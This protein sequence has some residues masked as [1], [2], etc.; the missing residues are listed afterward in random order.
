MFQSFDVTARPEQGPPRLKA[1]RERLAA[2]GLTGFIVP[3][4]DLHQGEYVAERDQRLQWL[5]GFTGSA[6]FCIV[7]PQIAGVFIDGR[8]RTQVKAQ[9]DLAHFT[10]VPWP[11]TKPGPWLVEQLPNGGVVGFDP[12]LH[13]RREIDEIETALDDKGVTLSPT[14]NFV[15]V[16]WTDQL[17]PSLGPVE[18][19]PETFAGE[20]AADKRGRLAEALAQNEQSAAV[21]TLPDS[22]SW[23]LNIRGSDVPR[24]PVVH[25]TAILHQTGSLDLFIAPAKLSD[26]V[27]AHLGPDVRLHPP[28]DFAGALG[29]LSGRVRVDKATAPLEVSRLLTGAGVTVAW[30]QD[31]CLL[32][33][34][35]KNAAEIEGTAEAHLRDGAAMAEF[36][37]WL[38]RQDPAGGLTEIDIVVALEGFRRA[39]NSLRE[40][41]F[42]TICGSGP[43]G[44]IMHYRVTHETNRTIC[45]GELIVVDSGGQYLDGTTDITRTVAMGDPGD[46]ARAC[47]TRV[48]QGMIAISRLR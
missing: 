27:R 16:V 8:Y 46:A 11:D 41:S 39:T 25:A 34:A 3:R 47:F 44:A 37:A 45:P 40:I 13:T 22:I 12:W 9:V 19:Y 17:A 30:D 2:E 26:A 24:N 4:A 5:T 20:S 28:G 7:L 14:A 33:K 36:L 32:P 6:G 48:L 31:P 23:L 1:L 29:R 35:R 21:I 42:E 18:V 10:P 38:A 43:N 15:D